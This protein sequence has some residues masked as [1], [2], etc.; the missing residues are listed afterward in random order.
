[1]FLDIQINYLLWL[2]HLRELSN[3]MFDTFFLSVTKFGEFIIPLTF[4]ALIY[5]CL[6]RRLG[7]FLV[8]TL[9]FGLIFNQF[10]KMFACI[11]RPWILSNK[12]HPVPDAIPDASGYS[13][14]SG[15]TI[16][17][18]SVWGGLASWLWNVKKV[19]YTM[20][21]LVLLVAFSRNYLGVHTPQ[22]VIVSIVMGLI[23]IFLLTPVFKKLN[24]ADQTSK[25]DET[26]KNFTEAKIFYSGIILAFIT[27][28]FVVVKSHFLSG[29]TLAEYIYQLPDFY[30]NLG[31]T[32]GILSG[33]YLCRKMISYSTEIKS[34]KTFLRF[35]FG[36]IGLYILI[37]CGKPVFKMNFGPYYGSFI[38][39][40]LT[41]IY[42]TF[43]YPWIFTRVERKFVQKNIEE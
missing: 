3:G 12:V 43:L 23:I 17:A 25:E 26:E 33:W 15:H 10:L 14:P 11:S 24:E 28:M 32:I 37:F 5:W 31:I 19:R 2:Q 30:S 6:N 8:I 4:A 9:S 38:G 16:K 13:F 35:I 1:M 20:I 42:L 21:T 27:L 36:I 7:E 39:S 34:G 41:G 40:F 22:D 29:E 18:I